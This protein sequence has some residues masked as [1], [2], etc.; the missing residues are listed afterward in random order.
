[1]RHSDLI[2]GT[3]FDRSV[4]TRR[5]ASWFEI[6]CRHG[7]KIEKIAL[8]RKNEFAISGGGGFVGPVLEFDQFGLLYPLQYNL[9]ERKG[10][11]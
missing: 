10:D 3:N 1:M 2:V 4:F 11:N 6:I 5:N 9:T 8:E 7:E